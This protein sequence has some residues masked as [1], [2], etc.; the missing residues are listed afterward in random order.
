MA[1]S[2]TLQTT[3]AFICFVVIQTTIDTIL[4][5]CTPYIHDRRFR[6]MFTHLY[7]FPATS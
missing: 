5:T 6:N 4:W 2:T 7:F 3:E 1:L